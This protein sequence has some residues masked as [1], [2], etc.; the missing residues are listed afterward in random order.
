MFCLFEGRELIAWEQSSCKCCFYLREYKQSNSIH[1]DQ[2]RPGVEGQKK[3]IYGSFAR[4][5]DVAMNR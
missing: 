1:G 2:K 5:S 4:E 3:Q